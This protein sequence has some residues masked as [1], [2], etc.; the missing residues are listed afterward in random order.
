M[1]FHE[2]RASVCLLCC[3]SWVGVMSGNTL[4]GHL[5]AVCGHTALRATHSALSFVISHLTFHIF[6]P[7]TPAFSSPED[8]QGA[9]NSAFHKI[10]TGRKTWLVA[11]PAQYKR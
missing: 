9:Q 10:K 5:R 11:G 3:G 8:A 4:S 2:T 7:R 1:Q 6:A